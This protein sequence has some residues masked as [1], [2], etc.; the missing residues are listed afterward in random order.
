[1]SGSPP[2]GLGWISVAKQHVV[3]SDVNAL[4]VH[5]A[6]RLPGIEGKSASTT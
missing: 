5:M 3:A 4:E 2:F 1:M 6:N